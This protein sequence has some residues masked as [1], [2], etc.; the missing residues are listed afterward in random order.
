MILYFLSS[1]LVTSKSIHRQVQNQSLGL[2]T[3]I[4]FLPV[5]DKP[6][7]LSATVLDQV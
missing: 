7:D 1:R 2:Q 3:V 5:K 6:K 4:K